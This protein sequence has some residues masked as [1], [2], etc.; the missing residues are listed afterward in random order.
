MGWQ[1]IL[2]INLQDT[3]IYAAINAGDV[4]LSTDPTALRSRDWKVVGNRWTLPDIIEWTEQTLQEDKDVE[5]LFGNDTRRR[6]S[7]KIPKLDTHRGK[8]R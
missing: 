7:P 5:D 2:K 6:F 8:E 4:E 3:Y 1:D